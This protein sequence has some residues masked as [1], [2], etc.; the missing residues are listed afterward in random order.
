MKKTLL[1]HLTLFAIVA[2]VGIL[3]NSCGEDSILNS[4]NNPPD[5][6][7]ADTSITNLH[8]KGRITFVDTN[9]IRSGGIYLIS[10][11]PRGGWPPMGGPISYDTVRVSGNTLEYCYDLG[12]FPAL[13]T[14]YVLSIGFR[15]STGG[16]SPI[17]SVYGCDTSH[18]TSCWLVNP[19]TVRI[20]PT[21]GARYV[22][23][24]S[25]SDT[26]KKVY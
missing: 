19:P 21:S 15:K 9:F 16:Q 4:G 12:G 17:M 22:N 26:T 1:K 20:S 5:T 14:T 8:I 11:Y 2:F 24:I 25:W 10:A 7:C 6:S 18:S 13:D 23:M 3:I